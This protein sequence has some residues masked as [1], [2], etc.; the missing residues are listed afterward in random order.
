MQVLEDRVA[1][2]VVT[3]V[4]PSTGDWST[5]LAWSNGSVPGAADTAYIGQGNTVTFSAG[6]T[7]QVAGLDVDG[8]FDVTGGTMT[9]G[10][11]S[12]SNFTVTTGGTISGA[13]AS[14]SRTERPTPGP[15]AR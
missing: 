5:P 9:I 12:G 1:P 10:S 13:G 8:T 6:D 4:G 11:A 14:I 3:W 15:A 2:A 7:G